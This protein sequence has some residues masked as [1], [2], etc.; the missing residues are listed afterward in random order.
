MMRENSYLKIGVLG[1]MGPEA[2][3]TFY[4]SLVKLFQ[5]ELQVRHNFEYPEMMIHNIPSPDNVEAGVDDELKDYLLNSVELLE[6]TGMHLLAIP[7]NSAHVHID[8]VT[9]ASNVVV[10][11]ILEETARAVSKA[12]V[13]R[14]LILGTESTLKQGIYPPHLQHREIDVVV[15]SPDHQEVIT[16]AIMAVCEGANDSTTKRQVLDV[17]ESYPDIEGVVLGC[18]EIPLIVSQQDMELP[19]FDTLQILV[20]ATFERCRA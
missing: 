13:K 9:A 14:V 17:I 5:T 7:C 8:A 10:M 19:C 11:N 15:P 3:A 12:K 20:R 4:L 16:R 2:S 1:G 6:Q 18:T